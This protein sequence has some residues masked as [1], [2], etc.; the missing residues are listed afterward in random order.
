MMPAG[1]LSGVYGRHRR[2]GPDLRL[3]WNV[4]LWVGPSVGRTRADFLP[5]LV[6]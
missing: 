4:Y 2:D 6:S 1:T 3:R 5:A